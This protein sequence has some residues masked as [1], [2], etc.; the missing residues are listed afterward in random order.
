M[1]DGNF[2]IEVQQDRPNESQPREDRRRR[3][4][5]LPKKLLLRGLR[6]G[7]R[8]A[9][10]E[11]QK[12]RVW[13]LLENGIV[14]SKAGDMVAASE[15]FREACTVDPNNKIALEMAAFA[16]NRTNDWDAAY[17]YWTKLGLLNETRGGP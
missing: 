14:A 13:R 9:S 6:K 10:V 11:R 15:A 16:A 7:P 12:D 2:D 1:P 17:E 8:R 4:L 5:I 3:T